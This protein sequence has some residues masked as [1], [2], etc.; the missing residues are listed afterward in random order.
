[1]SNTKRRSDILEVIKNSK[2]PISGGRLSELFNVSR[3]I[4]VQDIALLRAEGFDII[5]TTRGY[6][7]QTDKPRGLIKTIAVKHDASGMNDEL[8]IITSFGATILDIIVE[9]PVYGELRSNLMLNSVLDLE[10]FLKNF[11]D[12]NAELLSVVTNGVHLHSIEVP[13][14]QIYSAIRIEL[15]KRNILLVNEGGLDE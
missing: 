8:K 9:H 5:A 11:E 10:L 3:Q 1:M 14:E 12:N 15:Q 13:N 6:I 2:K 7:Y 4:V